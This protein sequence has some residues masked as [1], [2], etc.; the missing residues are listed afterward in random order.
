MTA[1][2]R[3]DTFDRKARE[4]VKRYAKA[5]PTEDAE[6]WFLDGFADAASAYGEYIKKEIKNFESDRARLT[7]DGPATRTIR[8][9]LNNRLC[10]PGVGPAT[11]CM[12][13]DSVRDAILEEHVD[14][15]VDALDRSSLTNISDATRELAFDALPQRIDAR[16]RSHYVSIICDIIER[17]S[18]G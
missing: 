2:A 6:G 3:F 7:Y 13:C 10:S 12:C 5:K 1:E 18:H 11:R 9:I 4:D 15:H 16:E 17:A 14:V 8:E